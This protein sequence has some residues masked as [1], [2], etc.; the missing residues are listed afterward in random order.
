[1]LVMLHM[2]MYFLLRSFCQLWLRELVIFP[3][4][5]CS[6]SG[7]PHPLTNSYVCMY[8]TSHP[9][10][11]I[12]PSQLT[13][14]PPT[15]FPN[16]TVTNTSLLPLNVSEALTQIDTAL[17]DGDITLR[18]F[19]LKKVAILKPFKHLVLTNGTIQFKNKI[20]VRVE[21]KSKATQEDDK[22][23][24]NQIMGGARKLLTSAPVLS[25]SRRRLP[26]EKWHSLPERSVATETSVFRSR[27]LLAEDYF[28]NSLK[29]VNMLYTKRYGHGARKVPAHMPHFIQRKVMESLQEEFWVEYD[30]TSS[31]KVRAS[32][33]M[34]F[35]FSYFYYLMSE[36]KSMMLEEVYRQLDTD[37]S[38]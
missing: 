30:V 9:P 14:P 11:R 5:S 1:M 2:Y 16:L 4:T 35:A 38:G 12:P 34:Q 3:S 6:L 31:H 32:D 7:K 17:K 36:K 20:N 25:D 13:P 29:H 23:T 21:N 26:W 15:T 28:A 27:K 37:Q 10:H 33:D 8:V 22:D 19:W 18:G 24:P